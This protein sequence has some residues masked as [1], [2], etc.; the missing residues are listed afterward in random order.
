MK[1][2][3]IDLDKEIMVIAEIGNNHE[4][5]YALAEEMIGKA[6]ECGVHAVKFQTMIPEKFICSSDVKRVEQLK[7]F[8][9]SYNEFEKL[10]QYAKKAGVIFLSTP[11][12]LET[13]DFLDTI[14]PA[15]K[16]SSSDNT[17]LPLLKKVASKNKPV[18]ISSGLAEVNEIKQA[19]NIFNESWG[20]EKIKD[21]LA[22]LHCVSNYPTIAA[23]ANLL[24]IKYI[25]EIFE[26]SAG[27]SDHTLG[28]DASIFAA[29]MGACIIEKH[30][31]INKN[32]SSFRDHQLS[33]DPSEMK[34]L[35]D[36][37]K[38]L[39]D[40]LG[41]YS[42]QMQDSEKEIKPLI[43]RSIAAKRD[44]S[45]HYNITSEDIIWVRPGT[46][47]QVGD[48]YLVIGKNTKKEIKA[49]ELIQL[50]DIN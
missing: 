45:N 12:D 11:F 9:L 41:S 29:S 10:A 17:F 24:S 37:I 30:F 44:L 14:V 32:Y 4:G 50:T 21:R 43:R 15:F 34:M 35:V 2:E 6:S 7:K 19:I 25:K 16:I 40:M 33:A 31:T 8:E 38:M 27:F 1:I 42:F 39:Q 23:D 47:M 49:G 46:G 20:I 5:S 3:N 36:K 22:I 28:I 18:M 26:C 13:V 48:E